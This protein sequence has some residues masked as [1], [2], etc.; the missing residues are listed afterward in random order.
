[1]KILGTGLSGLVGS[2]ITELLAADFSFENLSLETGVDITNK[3]DIRSRILS[4]DALWVFHFAAFTNVQ[5]AEK[6]KDLGEEGAVWKVNVAATS[7]IADACRE[8]GKHLLYIDTDYAFDGTKDL[9]TEEDVPNPQGWYAITKS[10]GARRVLAYDKGVVVRISNPYRANPTGKTDFVHKMLERLENGEDLTAPT[11]QLFVPTFIDD[12][13][14]AVEKIISIDAT[15]IYHVVA[16]RALS[17][18]DAARTV[19][20]TYG[21]DEKRIKGTSFA[22]YFQDRAPV[23]QYAVLSA[24]KLEKLGVRTRTFSEG[25]LEIYRQESYT[26]DL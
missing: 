20:R 26:N 7:H 17:P 12:L 25:V 2:R 8:T 13:A 5:E 18:F 24:E 14:V 16:S 15:G 4:S 19:A 10:E 21:Y 9:Y 3:E 1:M 11:D 6:Q 23:P 22:E